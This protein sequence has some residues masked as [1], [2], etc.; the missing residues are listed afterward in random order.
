MHSSQPCSPPAGVEPG[1]RRAFPGGKN[2][3]GV[4]QLIIN[5]IPPHAH[6]LEL[7][8]GSA[9]ILIRKRPAPGL[10]LAIE[11]D[12][13]TAAALQL[14][15]PRQ[16]I[17]GNAFSFLARY[18]AALTH[19]N[20]CIYADPPYPLETR[21]GRRYYAHELTDADHVHLL[22]TLT[23][24]RAIV[25]ISGYRCPLYDNALRAWRRIDYHTMTRGGSPRVESLWMNFPQPE[26]L[27]DYQFLG[28]DFRQRERIRKLIRRWRRRLDAMPTLQRAALR[29]ALLDGHA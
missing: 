16:V 1:P 27:H 21:Q 26:T 28:D 20:V 6:Y 8:A 14:A 29:A 17:H 24:A 9:A 25:L 19:P 23:H 2:A 12:A 7:F 5:Q 4:Y 11:A 22:D 13:A 10:N 18:P 3:D 15:P